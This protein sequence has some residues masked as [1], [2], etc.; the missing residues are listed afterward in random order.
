MQVHRI[1]SPDSYIT[2]KCIKYRN[3]ALPALRQQAEKTFLKQKLSAVPRKDL[4]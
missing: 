4:L 1:R 2:D 3:L